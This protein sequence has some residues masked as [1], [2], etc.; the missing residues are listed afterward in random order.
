MVVFLRFLDVS[1]APVARHYFNLSLPDQFQHGLLEHC[2][3]RQR[4]VDALDI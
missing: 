2:L 3:R 1:K 4:V